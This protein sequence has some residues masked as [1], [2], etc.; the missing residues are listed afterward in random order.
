VIRGIVL[1]AGFGRRIG[2]PKAL[3]KIGAE[4]FHER[5]VR[6]LRTN[7]LT[8]I[9]VVNSAVESALAP[10]SAN[11]SRI[12]NGDPDGSGMFGSV[13]LGIGHAFQSG[14]AGAVL[15]P[16]DHALVSRTDVA[17][18]VSALTNGAAIALPVFEGRRGHPIGV[19]REVMTEILEARPD[20][21]LR[22]VVHQDP[23][24]IV[25]VPASLG[26]VAGVNTL[27]DLERASILSFR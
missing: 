9:S 16:V 18:V 10:P 21:T 6:V 1:A 22:D 7:G 8:V 20:W 2:T 13:R 27:A 11:E 15:L 17:S 14:V 5:A 4:T 3:L 25:E 24:R 23:T 26:V 12:E 19:S